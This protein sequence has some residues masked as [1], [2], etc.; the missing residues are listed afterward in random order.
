MSTVRPASASIA[1]RPPVK[2]LPGYD[3]DDAVR[4]SSAPTSDKDP[5]KDAPIDA[6]FAIDVADVQRAAARVRR[7]SQDES[8][9]AAPPTSADSS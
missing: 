9:L 6:A 5:D 8:A 2:D 4:P 1:E 3:S 7:T